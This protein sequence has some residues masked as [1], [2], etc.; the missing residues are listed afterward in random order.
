MFKVVLS[1]LN[2]SPSVRCG[3]VGEWNEYREDEGK[4]VEQ[5]KMQICRP[6]TS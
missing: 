4:M 6:K 5:H 1:D 2:D 3:D